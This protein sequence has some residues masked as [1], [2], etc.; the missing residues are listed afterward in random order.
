MT[1]PAA[2]IPMPAVSD[3]R[4]TA[5]EHL[6]RFARSPQLCAELMTTSLQACTRDGVSLAGVRVGDTVAGR[7]GKAF[8]R[9]EAS[10]REGDGG[11][12]LRQF[13][14]EFFDDDDGRK[15]LWRIRRPH[16]KA[17]VRPWT[18]YVPSLRAIVR[19]L[20]YDYRL[21]TLAAVLAPGGLASAFPEAG[22][23]PADAA[24][25]REVVRYV[26]EKRC[27][28][29]V[30]TPDR[31]LLAKVYARAA[32]L[33]SARVQEVLHASTSR[34]G[35]IVPEVRGVCP[36]LRVMLQETVEGVPLYALLRSGVGCGNAVAAAAGAL[37]RLHACE[38]PGL[39]AH[40]AGA[41]LEVVDRAVGRAPL[42][43]NLQARA[44]ALVALLASRAADLRPSR[45]GFSHR[46]FYDK[47][48]I[49]GGERLTVIDFDTACVSFPE[50]DA[51]NFLAHVSL[52]GLQSYLPTRDV[53]ALSASFA[54]AYRQHR[55]L[56]E[57]VL[58]WS[59]ASAWLRLATVYAARPAWAGL[60]AQL[61]SLGEGA[62]AGG[63][64]GISMPWTR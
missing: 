61:L 31:R 32:D 43:G 38:V 41:E 60:P 13:V 16:P 19:E 50:L 29:R 51:G 49:V 57:Q 14:L 1:P 4:G 30:G 44:R 52:R 56:D 3:T 28:L 63:P 35:A 27:L 45:P 53:P 17:V 64:E 11:E 59:A 9:V 37:A 47:Q 7:R 6:Q 22:L 62:L 24:G 40:D 5:M 36:S 20:R 18:A 23:D 10:T 12:A 21:D 48:V 25:A 33:E 39:R 34:A 26:P 15:V 54:A 42:P 46:D 2:V 8:L 55:S 58:R